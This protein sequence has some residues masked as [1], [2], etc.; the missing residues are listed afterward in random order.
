MLNLQ[1]LKKVLECVGWIVF[2]MDVYFLL[3]NNVG[4]THTKVVF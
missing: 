2:V 1:N 4:L 3:Q